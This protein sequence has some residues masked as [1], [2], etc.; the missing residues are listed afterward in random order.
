MN[1]NLFSS[2][3][4]KEHYEPLRNL[5]DIE[6]IEKTTGRTAQ[7][8]YLPMQ[9][10]DVAQTWAD[11]SELTRDFGYTP[12]TPIAEGVEAFVTWYREY[13]KK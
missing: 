7:K 13:Y 8:E 1:S 3:V 9:P 5:A 6:A 12:N 2:G 10:G 4:I 11:V